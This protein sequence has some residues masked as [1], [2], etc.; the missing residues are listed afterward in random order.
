MD[1]Y[2]K[3]PITRSHNGPAV[4]L[5]I[6]DQQPGFGVLQELVA[7]GADQHGQAD[8]LAQALALH[9]CHILSHLRVKGGISRLNTVRIGGW[10]T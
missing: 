9:G 6:L 10:D 8:A 1:C 7:I 4:L 5:I 2:S 3:P